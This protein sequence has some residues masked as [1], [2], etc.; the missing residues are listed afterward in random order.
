MK[1]YAVKTRMPKNAYVYFNYFKNE[2]LKRCIDKKADCVLEFLDGRILL[3]TDCNAP[4]ELVEGIRG[5]ISLH[6]ISIFESMDELVSEM[7]KA[8]EGCES[9]AIRSNRKS[10]EKELGERILK[11]LDITVDLSSPSCLLYVEK[12]GK[13]Y[14]LFLEY[15]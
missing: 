13:F 2:V 10:L 9:F 12:R 11:I 1:P 7:I 14:L 15:P 8:L 5:F 3:F 4:Q 6:K